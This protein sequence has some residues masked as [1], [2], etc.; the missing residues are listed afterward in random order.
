MEARKQSQSYNKGDLIQSRKKKKW[1][2]GG[3]KQ[4]FSSETSGQ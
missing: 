1:G 2:A 3:E 4:Y